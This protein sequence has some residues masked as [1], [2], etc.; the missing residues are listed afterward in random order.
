MIVLAS[1][2]L[3]D[4]LGPIRAWISPL[5]TSKSSPLRISLPSALTCRFVISRSAI[6]LRLSWVFR[7]N[8]LCGLSGER[9]SCRV[10]VGELHQVRKRGPGERLGDSTVN[11]G[12]QK[13]G[14]AGAVAVALV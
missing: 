5:E 6:F 7:E 14:R 9:L 1:V 11:P 8:G 10:L 13:L 3:P 2:D 4:P 12:P